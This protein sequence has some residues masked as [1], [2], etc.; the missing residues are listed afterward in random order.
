MQLRSWQST[1]NFGHGNSLFHVGIPLLL[2]P[3]AQAKEL[4]GIP[5]LAHQASGQ[6][7]LRSNTPHWQPC[8]T[9]PPNQRHAVDGL[10]WN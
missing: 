1:T 8:G 4:R 9:V 3:D 5:S 10:G 6:I 7:L 2:E